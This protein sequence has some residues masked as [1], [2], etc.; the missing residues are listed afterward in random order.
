MSG[1]SRLWQQRRLPAHVLFLED[2]PAPRSDNTTY[3]KNTNK[4]MLAVS[5][6]RL[7]KP[8]FQYQCSP[9]LGGSPATAGASPTN[10]GTSNAADATCDEASAAPTKGRAP[11]AP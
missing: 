10:I 3:R 4:M 8:R 9:T 1:E 6:C 2:P 7:P 5:P 11:S